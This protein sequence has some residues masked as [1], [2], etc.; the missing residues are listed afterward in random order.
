MKIPYQLLRAL[1]AFFLPAGNF[2]YSQK[3]TKENTSDVVLKARY[4]S[5]ESN[6]IH[7]YNTNGSQGKSDAHQWLISVS[8]NLFFS[9]VSHA[10]FMQQETITT[11]LKAYDVKPGNFNKSGIILSWGLHEISASVA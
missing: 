10:Q 7:S 1:C 6:P 2:T 3:I 9:V 4:S 8:E 11:C 5:P